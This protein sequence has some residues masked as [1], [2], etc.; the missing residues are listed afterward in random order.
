MYASKSEENLLPEL[1]GCNQKQRHFSLSKS[2]LEKVL[3]EAKFRLDMGK[4]GK[5]VG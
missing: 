1:E 4:I 2:H 5:E 3:I